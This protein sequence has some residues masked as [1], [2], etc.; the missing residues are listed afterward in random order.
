[1]STTA[2]LPGIS[3][4]NLY[5]RE[6][7][8]VQ[9]RLKNHVLVSPETDGQGRLVSCIL[10]HPQTGFYL[11]DFKVY[12]GGLV[13]RG[14]VSK[15]IYEFYSDDLHIPWFGNCGVTYA[16]SKCE[17]SRGGRIPKD[18][19]KELAIRSVEEIIR[20]PENFG[21]PA[22]RM[23]G[24]EWRSYVSSESTWLEFL[25]TEFLGDYDMLEVFHDAGE[26]I[27]TF[28]LYHILGA[29]RAGEL[30]AERSGGES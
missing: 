22:R 24:T 20:D 29:R 23:K 8:I 17:A 26:H 4:T 2:D 11:M 30:F 5:E 28:V 19:S 18:W 7:K 14:D 21:D 6:K 13:V 1:M 25:N 10:R 16:A 3:Q 15:A 12:R 27:S 9:E